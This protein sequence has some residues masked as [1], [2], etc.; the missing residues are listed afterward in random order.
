LVTYNTG[1][2]GS[3]KNLEATANTAN[4]YSTAISRIGRQGY[5]VGSSGSRYPVYN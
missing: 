4:S 3:G 1:I 2:H 5:P